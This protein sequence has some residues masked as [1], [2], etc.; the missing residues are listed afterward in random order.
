M[1]RV[2]RLEQALRWYSEEAEAIARNLHGK[3]VEDHAKA[4]EASLTVLA[5]DAGKRG[6]DALGASDA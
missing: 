5:L 1:T 3:K 6:K 2:E 4:I